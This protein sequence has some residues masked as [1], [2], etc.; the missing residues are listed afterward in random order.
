MS[1]T[2]TTDGS[3]RITF[4]DTGIVYLDQVSMMGKDAIDNNGFRPDLFKAVESLKPPCIRWPGGYY[5]ELYRWKDGIGPQHER[6]AF[7][8]EAWNDRDVN[9]FGIDEFMTLCNRLNA[10]PII[11]INTGHRYSTSPQTQ[12]IEE[13]KHWLEYCNGPATST[14]GAV[15]T[16]NG[17]PEPYNV[18][19]WEMGNEIWLTRKCQPICEFPES[20]CSGFKSC[21]FFHNNYRL[22]Q[23]RL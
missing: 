20:I 21:R 15:R 18:K 12:Y 6:G 14:W 23:Q 4:N 9:S 3:L 22:W 11:V 13:A 16:A 7:P 8:V 10:E 17:H 1:T 19:Y 2:E 5:S